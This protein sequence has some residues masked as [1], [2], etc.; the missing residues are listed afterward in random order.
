MKR[1]LEALEHSG[2]LS[3]TLRAF[4]EALKALPS[5]VTVEGVLEFRE[6]DSGPV[7]AVWV[8]AALRDGRAVV[9]WMDVTA[10]PAGLVVDRRIS[11]SGRDTLVA[12][13]DVILQPG[14]SFKTA[15]AGALCAL[16]ST[17]FP[18]LESFLGPRR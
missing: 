3:S 13:P 11:E 12:F 4:Q 17:D 18:A 9:W 10:T 16:L 2:T 14:D 1:E 5:V 8:D 7:L 15:T 6:Y